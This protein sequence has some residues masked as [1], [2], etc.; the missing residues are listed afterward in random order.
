L[1]TG[2]VIVAAGMSTRMHD[3]KQLMKIDGMALAERVAVNF[4]RAGIKDIVMV[5]GYR[6]E[7]VEKELSH[8]GIT[9]LWNR[10]YETTQMFDSAKMGLAALKDRCDSILFCPADVPFFSDNTAEALLAAK[11]KL[12][13]PVSNGRNGHPI[14]IDTDLIPRIL[15][16]QGDRGLKGAL[17]SLDTKPVSLYVEDEGSVTDA[18]TKEDYHHLEKIHNTR[19]ANTHFAPASRSTPPYSK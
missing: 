2:A 1:K 15:E 8:L 18:D 3:F 9:F 12:V 16:Y 17:D 14:R 7:Q 5:T 19:Q 6:A 4:Q 10:D 11:G 13:F